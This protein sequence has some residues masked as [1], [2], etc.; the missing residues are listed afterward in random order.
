MI[1]N[2]RSCHV[3]CEDK[4]VRLF[5]P[6]VSYWSPQSWALGKSWEMWN[7]WRKQLYLPREVMVSWLYILIKMLV[8]TQVLVQGDSQP[9]L[10]ATCF[11]V[12]HHIH[13]KYSGWL[14]GLKALTT[15]PWWWWSL[16]SRTYSGR[17]GLVSCSSLTSVDVHRPPHITHTH[18]H[19]NII[20]LVTVLMKVMSESVRNLKETV[21]QVKQDFLS[22]LPESR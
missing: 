12:T 4:V 22:Y 17:R 8:P 3:H 7:H 10:L 13:F 1:A 21:V 5:C 14:S 19:Q 6:S 16:S 18:T 2:I 9:K 20:E 15:E 11:Y